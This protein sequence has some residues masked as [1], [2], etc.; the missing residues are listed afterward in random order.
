MNLVIHALIKMCVPLAQKP[1]VL[2]TGNVCAL[3]ALS[4]RKKKILLEI[5]SKRNFAKKVK[6]FFKIN[7]FI[8]FWIFFS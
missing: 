6:N 7:Q 1:E 2:L 3:M 4:L 8:Y 5:W